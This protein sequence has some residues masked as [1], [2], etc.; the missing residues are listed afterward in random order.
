MSLLS[1]VYFTGEMEIWRKQRQWNRE[2]HPLTYLFW[3]ATV[4]CNFKCKHCGSA[5]E[6]LKGKEELT[7]KEIVRAFDQISKDFNP[8][9]IMVAITGG[10]PLL[11]ND[12]IEVGHRLTGLG[13]SWGIVTNGY[14][15]DRNMAQSLKDA[16]M[17]TVVVSIDDIGHL[18]DEF[19]GVSMAYEK[20]IQAIQNLATVG[21]FQD[22]QI[23]TTVTK[24]TVGRLEDM[25]VEFTKLPITSWRVMAISPIGR[26]AEHTELLLN[27]SDITTL[28][29]FILKTNKT[30]KAPIKLFY[31]CE[32]Y[33]GEQYETKTRPYFFECKA[34]INVASILYNGD[35]FVC[36]NVPR[37][38]KLI[39]GNVRVDRFKDVWDKKFKYFRDPALFSPKRCIGCEHWDYCGGGSRHLGESPC[40]MIME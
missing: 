16:G 19:R 20:A 24:R 40:Y 8:S 10:E 23:T 1:H 27:K 33:L 26:A 11:R 37:P 25:Y 3:E 14:L 29:E 7:T 35:I 39:Q 28:L 6:R 4:R 22:I 31:G 38:E 5:Y 2:N 18:H 32:N 17:K 36:P 13:F 12:L 15:L 30:R 9:Q 21:G 34:G